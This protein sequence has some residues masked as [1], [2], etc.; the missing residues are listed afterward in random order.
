MTVTDP[1][2]GPGP[3]PDTTGWP[4]ADLETLALERCLARQTHTQQH[5]GKELVACRACLQEV[6][7]GRYPLDFD[8]GPV[9]LT[10]LLRQVPPPTKGWSLLHLAL[11]RVLCD[12]QWHA[13]KELEA[14]VAADRPPGEEWTQTNI[15]ARL[16]DLRQ[17]G[18]PIPQQTIKGRGACYRLAV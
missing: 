6:L 8:A 12:R 18:Y 3:L 2:P 15:S 7:I 1:I 5:R 13:L 10:E 14:G 9:D 11:L 4:T 17:Y 16:R